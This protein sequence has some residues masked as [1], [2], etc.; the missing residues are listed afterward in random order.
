MVANM[1]LSHRDLKVSHRDIKE[2]M[3]MHTDLGR[4]MSFS[5]EDKNNDNFA[6]MS[7]L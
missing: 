6:R 2:P 3:Y 4:Q 7:H 5:I 1:K